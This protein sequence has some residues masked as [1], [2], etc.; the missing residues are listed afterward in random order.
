SPQDWR[1]ST[2]G[3]L[4]LAHRGAPHSTR[5]LRRS[6]RRSIPA[7]S[8]LAPAARRD[9][10]AMQMSM[11]QENI[12]ATRR[13]LAE[14]RAAC[15]RLAAYP[16]LGQAREDRTDQPVCFWSVRASHLIYRPDTQPLVSVRMVHS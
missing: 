16:H 10:R 6:T 7:A 13:V 4:S 12:Q 5:N 1:S 3:Q 14:I 11:A 8:I 2:G 9:L 15:A